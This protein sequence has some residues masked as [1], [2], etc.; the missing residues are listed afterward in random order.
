MKKL[1][2]I[3]AA[4]SLNLVIGSSNL[5]ADPIEAHRGAYMTYQK[6]RLD[7]EWD[8]VNLAS[9]NCNEDLWIFTSGT[10]YDVGVNETTEDLEQDTYL[11]ESILS[12]TSG[13]VYEYHTHP[14]DY[15]PYPDVQG[16]S[17]ESVSV[18][19]VLAHVLL[20]ERVRSQGRMLFSRVADEHGIWSYTATQTMHNH[21]L[22]MDANEIEDMADSVSEG[23]STLLNIPLA[24]FDY[25]L[26]NYIEQQRRHGVIISYRRFR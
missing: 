24:H 20:S 14:H 5:K 7:G 26:N 21:I 22:N 18:Q 19:D 3:L 15:C 16:I 8:L 4:L 2:T 9:N 12:T 10:W 6:N 25:F 23:S 13:P 17:L 11:I 1:K